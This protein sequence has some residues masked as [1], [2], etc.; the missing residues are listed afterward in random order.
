MG[1]FLKLLLTIAILGSL[2]L[3]SQQVL[4]QQWRPVR[5]GILFGISGMAMI[6]QQND[7][8]DLLI[9]HDNKE[10]DQGR[11]AIITIKGKNQPE[12][13]P[14]QWPKNTDLPIDLEGITSVP[15]SY[16]PSFMALS[17][18]GKIYHI[19]LDN[20]TKNI[21]VLKVFN[22]Q[23]IPDRSN[24]EAFALQE[25][26]AKLLAVWAHRGKSEEAA[27]IY[28]GILNPATYQITKTGSVN[29]KVPWPTSNV[30]HI[31]DLKIDRAGILFITS[32]SDPGNDG[33]FESA[34]YV[35]G[36]FEISGNGIEFR[37]N[38]ELVPLY[39][40][41]YHKIEAIEL[42]PGAGGGVI[43]GTDDENMGSFV[44]VGGGSG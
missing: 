23:N 37:Q 12:Y 43:V 6:Q 11:L 3:V 25:I 15:G 22:L 44:Y 40:Y 24:F 27:I 2:L 30:R 34:V 33:P 8:L 28:W 42:V 4:A 18:S 13:F 31:S 19:K 35:A 10:K 36:A 41:D 17:S 1:R 29:L 20:S 26:D 14:L 38:P 16:N 9:V 32:A 5:G 39:R 21:S 7:S